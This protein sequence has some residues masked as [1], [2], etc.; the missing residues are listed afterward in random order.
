[1]QITLY[2]NVGIHR[3][4]TFSIQIDKKQK[5]I[6][7]NVGSILIIISSITGVLNVNFSNISEPKHYWSLILSS[8]FILASVLLFYSTETK[9]K[10]NREFKSK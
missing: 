2:K 7:R 8:F 5:M 9:F 3:Q 4:N 1:M 10:K 6:K